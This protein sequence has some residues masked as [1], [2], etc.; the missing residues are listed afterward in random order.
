MPAP[1]AAEPALGSSGRCLSRLCP[2]LLCCRARE[3]RRE[4]GT[5]NSVGRR[6]GGTI[7]SNLG[8][9]TDATAAAAASVPVTAP[10]LLT[11]AGEAAAA[12]A[13]AGT[14][15]TPSSDSDDGWLRLFCRASREGGTKNSVVRREGGTISSI[16]GLSPVAAKRCPGT[17]RSRF[18][19]LLIEVGLSVSSMHDYKLRDVYRRL[20][21]VIRSRKVGVHFRVFCQRTHLQQHSTHTCTH[22]PPPAPRPLITPT[23]NSR[24]AT[25]S[26]LARSRKALAGPSTHRELSWLGNELFSS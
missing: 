4:G 22:P 24:S 15:A 13:S 11:P 7:S 20:F 6:D 25:A 12:S 26:A 16:L 19:E 14:A 8:L 10:P 5:K 17:D 2:R 21:V 1:A 9:P 23:A 18:A 3:G